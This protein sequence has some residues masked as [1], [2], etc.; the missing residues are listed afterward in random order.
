MS[1]AIREVSSSSRTGLASPRRRTSV[2]QKTKSSPESTQRPQERSSSRLIRRKVASMNVDETEDSDPPTALS[3]D[4]AGLVRP[5][6]ANSSE[7]LSRLN[8][9]QAISLLQAERKAYMDLQN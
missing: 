5:P 4:D 7:E 3:K 2:I 1:G 6:A 9:E 8:L